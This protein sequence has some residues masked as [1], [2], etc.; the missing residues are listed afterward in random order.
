MFLKGTGKALALTVVPLAML[1]AP[2][3]KAAV[4]EPGFYFSDGGVGGTGISGGY[5]VYGNSLPDFQGIPG[6]SLY[7][8]LITG[9]LACEPTGDLAS[10]ADEG[11]L[12]SGDLHIWWGG[13]YWEPEPNLVVPVS[14][15]FQASPEFTWAVNFTI[16]GNSLTVESLVPTPGDTTVTGVSSLVAGSGYTWSASLDVH[17]RDLEPGTFSVLVPQYTT[18]DLNS[19]DDAIPEPATLLLLGP[20]LGFLLLKRRRTLN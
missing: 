6:I 16:G 19:A 20:A 8:D 17:W 4:M 3:A 1:A 7:S 2:A 11:G 13:D 18:L 15:D 10:A 9:D 12:C 5:A 14:W